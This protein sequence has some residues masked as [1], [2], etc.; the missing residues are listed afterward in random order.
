MAQN[1]P[2]ILSS[3]TIQNSRQ[4]L[5]DRDKA[6]R[7]SHS[8]TVFPVIDI[9]VGMLCYREDENTTYQLVSLSPLVW[10]EVVNHNLTQLYQEGADARYL[11][12]SGDTM[13]GELAYAMGATQAFRSS[14][15]FMRWQLAYDGTA[16]KVSRYSAAGAYQSLP[17]QVTD[18]GEVYVEGARVQARLGYTPYNATG[19]V[20]SGS[21]NV[22]GGFA[23]WGQNGDAFTIQTP[24]AG[25]SS[26]TQMAGISFLI[27]NMYGVKLALRGD[28][29]FGLGGWSAA[30]WRWYV[31][32]TNGDMVAAGNVQAFSDRKLKKDVARIKGALDIVTQMRGVRYT[33]KDTGER[34]IGVIAQEI[35]KLAPELVTRPRRGNKARKFWSVSYGNFAALFIEAIKELTKEVRILRREQRYLARRLAALEK[36][37]R[38]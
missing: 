19:G 31:N 8:G 11:N 12:V 36:S 14:A 37:G 27:P 33:R 25:G 9:E 34:H 28:G 6:I 38:L 5:L 16:L 3:E 22:Q 35:A 23:S 21:V 2:V 26:D 7:T 17:F 13:V 4:K 10:E 15:G 18:A 1:Y 32:T 24:T 29:Y 20:V 30:G